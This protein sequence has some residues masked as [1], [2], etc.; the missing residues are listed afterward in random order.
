MREFSET[1]SRAL[2]A[3]MFFMIPCTMGIWVMAGPACHLAFQYGRFAPEATQAAAEAT[4]LYALGLVG[5]SGVKILLPAYYAR[6]NAHQPLISSII[7]M[8]MNAGL[9]L[10]TFKFFSDSHLRFWGLALASSLGSF[11]NLFLLLAGLD[12]LGV[13][14]LWG[15]LAKEGGKI[16][17]ASLMMAFASWGALRGIQYLDLPVSR[18]FNFIFPVA[19]GVLV[20]FYLAKSMGLAGLDWVRQKKNGSKIK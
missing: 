6:R 19:V 4:V 12:Q 20:Y 17:L 10:A 18:F 5:Y 2:S 1:L 3:S 16:L 14:L 7:A 9:N 15:F 11:I 8:V 13:R